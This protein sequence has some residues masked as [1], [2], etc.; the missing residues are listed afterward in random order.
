MKPQEALNIVNQATS[1]APLP[2]E[3]H[4]QVIQ[5]LDVLQGL[6]SKTEAQE[7]TKN[8]ASNDNK[9]GAE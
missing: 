4:M 6:V 1:A 3:A 8:T 2:R 9:E 5:A 7:N